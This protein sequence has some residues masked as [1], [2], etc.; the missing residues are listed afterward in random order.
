MIRLN[1]LL[2]ICALIVVS[3]GPSKLSFNGIELTYTESIEIS[4]DSI[5]SNMKDYLRQKY[6]DSVKITYDNNGNIRLDHFGSGDYG[7]DYSI[8]NA[9]K[10]TSFVKWKNL[11]TIYFYDTR[12]NGYVLDT[13][14]RSIDDNELTISYITD[15]SEINGKAV[16]SMRFYKDSLSI[17]P[18]LYSEFKDF[19]FSDIL[20]ESK[21]LPVWTQLKSGDIQLTRELIRVKRLEHLEQNLFEPDINLPLKEYL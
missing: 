17:D 15:H 14:I 4:N 13:I 2:I 1:I 18:N 6:G 7:L 20:K 16:Q 8:Y 12:E 9:I 11:D 5:P 3:C 10:H 19:F 21:R